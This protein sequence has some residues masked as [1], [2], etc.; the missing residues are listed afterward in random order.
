MKSLLTIL[1]FSL[2]LRL[3]FITKVP[4]SLNWDET[5]FA[6][7][8]YSVLMTG[9]D[10]YGK[11]LPIQF[12]SIGDF[13][14]PM[15][16]YLLIPAIKVFGLN[17]FTVR[18]VPSLLGSLSVVLFSLIAFQISKNKNIAL[19]SGLLLSISPWHLQFTRAGADV[20]VAT[21]FTILGIA[22]FLRKKYTFGFLAFVGST[23]SYFGER[24][25]APMVCFVL[26]V[27]FRSWKIKNTLIAII[28]FLPLA[29]V[30]LSSGHL[31]KVSM[32]TLFSYK[33]PNMM[34]YG[35]M[36]LDRYSAHFS[37]SFLFIKGVDDFRQ[38]ILGMG[39][40]YWSD[41]ILLAAGIPILINQI[42]KRNINY[43]FVLIWLLI[44]PLP[45]AITRDPVH[46]RRALNMIYPLT[47]IA[48]LGLYQ[49]LKTKNKVLFIFIPIFA[50][51]LLFYLS[52]YYSYTP[53]AG[54]IG[55]AG[56]QYG[57]K[58]LVEYISPIKNNYKKIVVDTSYLGPYLY[59]LFYEQYSP[60]K[61]QPQAKLVRKETGGFG[62]GSGYEN[63][64]FRNI[65][66]P[67]E[68]GNSKYLF[69]GTPE[70]IPLKDIDPN[71]A[72]LL[73]SIYAPNG[74]EVFRV[75]ETK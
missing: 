3:I 43:V 26:M 69:A 53:K 6:Y 47:F 4:A 74:V 41:L 18:F 51:S 58:Q 28:A 72:R 22:L 50:W 7:N 37:P 9:K 67:D 57:Y 35:T 38:R 21:F 62:E 8:A 32:T 66:W 73:K 27:L 13:K 56:W 46:A 63:Y 55:P 19:L 44:S 61:Y 48:S 12:E 65:Y 75:V 71:K 49:I 15:Y 60:E 24:M 36:I 42:K 25:F 20:A 52:S 59:F 2:F 16:I 40:M 17:D 33:A 70:K 68:R 1:F 30:L 23:Y 34:A 39:M 54:S 31:N 11:I 10:E 64:E 5:S 29:L 14:C 45:A